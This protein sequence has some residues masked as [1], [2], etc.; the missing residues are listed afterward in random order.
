[1]IGAHTWRK[2]LRVHPHTVDW[3]RKGSGPGK[4]A[5]QPAEPLSASLPA[6]RYEIPPEG[7][8]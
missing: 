8:R 5:P 2:L 1:V 6:V 7:G 3:S 4:L